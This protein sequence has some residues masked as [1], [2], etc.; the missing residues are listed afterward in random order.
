MELNTTKG[1]CNSISLGSWINSYN[2][3]NF[4]FTISFIILFVVQLIPK[5]KKIYSIT[6]I[7]LSMICLLLNSLLM[8]PNAISIIKV[9]YHLILTKLCMD[10]NFI[11]MDQLYYEID[12]KK[13]TMNSITFDSDNLIKKSVIIIFKFLLNIYF[14]SNI[15]FVINTFTYDYDSKYL[16]IYYSINSFVLLFLLI[17]TKFECQSIYNLENRDLFFLVNCSTLFIISNVIEV[18][19]LNFC[20]NHQFLYPYITIINFI[21]VLGLNYI[22]NFVMFLHSTHEN[23]YLE[24]INFDMFGCNCKYMNFI[25]Y[26]FPILYFKEN[27]NDISLNYSD[28]LIH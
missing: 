12:T 11:I 22:V 20:N 5:K 15:Y 25:F 6:N 13:R 23:Y 17:Y 16:T 19:F 2:I 14:Y 8:I 4:I 24:S 28:Y 27:N 26:I 9:L 7:I 3:V 18:I 10:I 21:R 1:Y